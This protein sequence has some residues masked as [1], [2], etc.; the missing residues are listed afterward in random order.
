MQFWSVVG[1]WGVVSEWEGGR[2][3]ERGGEGEERRGGVVSFIYTQ[4][5]SIYREMRGGVRVVFGYY[6]YSG[7]Y[8]VYIE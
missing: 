2:G 7:K 3:G 4:V 5:I 6:I 8:R 1:Y